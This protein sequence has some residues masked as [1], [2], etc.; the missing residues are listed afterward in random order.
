MT[1]RVRV[2]VAL[3]LGLA[4]QPSAAQSPE[5]AA[6]ERPAPVRLA[7]V[8]SPL[9]AGGR[10]AVAGINAFS[11]DLYHRTLKP[12]E[13]HFLSPASVSVAVGLAYR[14]ARGETAVEL[15]RVLRFG[16]PPGEYL[17]TNAQILASINFAGPGR[18]LRTGNA[19]WLQESMSLLPEYVTD[20]ARFAGAGL[21][22]VDFK[23]G[24]DTARARINDWVEDRT[25]GKIKDL[26]Q[27][28]DIGL[29]TRAVLVNT[30]YWKGAWANTFAKAATRPEPF[31][32][33]VGDKSVIPLMH[34]QDQFRVIER[35]GVKA[36]SLPYEGGE[37]EMVVFLPNS[38][39]GLPPFEATL[40]PEEL[41]GWFRALEAAPW[42]DTVLTL[43]KMHVEWRQDLVDT[44]K[45]AGASVAF[46]DD[47]D[48]TGMMSF[49]QTSEPLAK[50]LTISKVVHQTYLDVDEVGSE[51]AAATAVI[52]DIIVTGKGGPPP[53]PPFI[54]RADKPF[55]FLLRD[56]RTGL[57]LF[58]GRYVAPPAA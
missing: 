14:G 53:P 6:D 31:T 21:Q 3:G 54:F 47:A 29:L 39:K 10:A 19:L 5:T 22:Y 50:G 35:G 45:A 20:M 42:R 28:A 26:L 9:D 12:G 49:P 4:G 36:I 15:E 7:P 18:E 16:Q 48:F 1:M 33:L 52:M 43:P 44:L 17:R 34:Q 57:I 11:L 55:L 24:P 25:R 51:A 13:N 46:S 56:R 40:T 32:T 30:I 58:M 41:M 38:P 2:L 23:Q 37:I 8:P 27:P